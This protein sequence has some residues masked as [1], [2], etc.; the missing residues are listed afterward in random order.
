MG[1]YSRHC[2]RPESVPLSL[3]STTPSYFNDFSETDDKRNYLFTSREITHVTCG[4]ILA[5]W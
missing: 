3:I 5:G 4:L 1:F 2:L